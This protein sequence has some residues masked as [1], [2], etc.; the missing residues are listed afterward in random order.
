MF[1][2]RKIT[3]HYI[4]IYVLKHVACGFDVK[5]ITGLVCD[6]ILES[7]LNLLFQVLKNTTLY[8]YA[9]YSACILPVSSASQVRFR[10]ARLEFSMS[11]NSF[12][13]FGVDKSSL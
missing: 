2:T 9:T 13:R 7:G 8:M 4:Y 1:V 11:V 12:L 3:C 6:H 10:D 5:T